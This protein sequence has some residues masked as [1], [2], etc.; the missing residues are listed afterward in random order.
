MGENDEVTRM[1]RMW[2][3]LLA[4]VM[5][6]A[7][8]VPTGVMAEEVSVRYGVVTDE[9][10]AV[11]KKA[12]A[13]ED[14]WFRVDAGHVTPIIDQKT[15]S[16]VLWYKVNTEHPVP[17]GRTY[18]GW[19]R[20]DCIREMTAA[21]IQAYLNG[22]EIPGTD[23]EEDEGGTGMLPSV[24]DALQGGDHTEYTG[25]EVVGGKGVVTVTANFRSD[26]STKT[27][28]IHCEI[29][30]GTEVEIT[31]VPLE[32][33]TNGWYRVTYN[34]KHGYV[35]C[36]LI[37]LLDAGSDPTPDPGFGTEVTGVYGEVNTTK[38]NFRRDAYKDSTNANVI[39]QLNPGQQF[40][41]LTVPDTVSTQTWYRVRYNGE[42]GY[43]Q[44]NFVTIVSGETPAPVLPDQGD[45]EVTITATGMIT[46]DKVNFRHE[47]DAESAIY[48]K[49]HTGTVVELLSIPTKIDSDHWYKVRY[50]G[51]T[52]YIQ[53]PYIRVL[54]VDEDALPSVE[55]FGY[56]KLLEDSVNLRVSAGGDPIVSWKGKGTLLR[57]TGEAVFNSGYNWYPVYYASAHAIYFV[58]EDM[59]QVMVVEGGE[60]NTPAPTESSF[61][62]IVTTKVGVN[63]RTIDAQGNVGGSQ[64]QVPKNTI[65]ACIG[66]AMTPDETNSSYTWYKVR[67]RGIVG[68]LRGDCVRVCTST[69]GDIVDP[70]PEV[71]TP[72]AADALSG[73]IRLIKDDVFL[74]K[75]EGGNPLTQLPLGLI[76]PYYGEITPAGK[77]G[78]YS[79][80]H[81]KTADGL[82]GYI[83]GDCAAICDESGVEV[84]PKPDG[85]DVTG[86]K[87][88]LVKKANFRE[89]ATTDS[90]KLGEI[91]LNT[92]VDVLFVPNNKVN[93]WYKIQ[94][95]GQTGYVLGSLIEVVEADS[96]VTPGPETSAFG[97]L[98]I[99]DEKVA[100]RNA[101][102]GNTVYTRLEKGTVWPLTGL[103]KEVGEVKWYPVNVNGQKG[104]VHG[105]FSFKLSPTQEESYLAGNGVP[106]ENPEVDNALTSYIIAT[107]SVNLRASYST[108]S[109]KMGEIKK[110]T[111]LYYSDTK[112]VGG[113][114]TWYNVVYDHKS[115]WVHGNFVKVMTNKEYQDYIASNPEE[116]PDTSA[117]LGYVKLIMDKV[118]IRDSAAGSAIDQ[119]RI[120]TVLPYYVENVDDAAGNYKWYRIS[121]EDGKFG[122]IRADMVEKC[123]ENG[124]PLPL[125]EPDLGETTS[126]PQTQ[127]MT[128]YTNLYQ[129]MTN[130]DAN[131]ARVR[132]LVQELINQGYYTGEMTSSYTTQVKEAVKLFQTAKGLSATGTA[133]S[134]TQHALF[135]TRPD[136]AGDTSNL[137]FVHY[138]AEKIDWFTGG[139]Q[140]LLPRGSKFKI[141]DVKTG[142]V[143]W[144]YRQ[145]GGKHMDIET[146][147]AA[148]SKRLC[149]IYG[150]DTLQEI[151][152]EN[153]WYP[154]RACLVTIGTRTFA[155]SLDGMQHGD[156]TIANNGMDGQVC[157]HFYNSQGHS[158]GEV[159]TSHAEAVE[160]A[161]Q[162]AP[163]GKK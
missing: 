59:I 135:G 19:I 110:G 6:L 4:I 144:A 131:Q 97:Y 101:P 71:T 149:Q 82:E 81:V 63:L 26:P 40:E 88:R 15:V 163:G 13:N 43:I 157:L 122:Y 70:E 12:G 86:V 117:I 23:E 39:V 137:D 102:G 124:D 83:R 62:Y 127:Q 53:A 113:T 116:E 61:G 115:V 32:G 72:P 119:L 24:D 104:Y 112:T 67:Y 18:I 107:D 105:G 118:Y 79:W 159:S 5:C 80:Y 47:D 68:Y 55:L 142:I 143:F 76:L 96:E 111:V 54:S 114:V 21:E 50:N 109:T 85:T 158:S 139:I 37:E 10:V 42:V 129:G 38:V 75:D 57:I 1:K 156:D 147:T 125:P 64:A 31:G 22:Q 145:A 65:L 25:R 132:N 90:K 17:N 58:R 148:D 140:E 36:D 136:G 73:Y 2:K 120:G 78:K 161:Y 91:P 74:R 60:L 126:A 44:A 48:G 154:R 155:C 92:I 33:D 28:T 46:A 152:D 14:L 77:V 160:Y 49:V 108:D 52:G 134:A 146:L 130:S 8:I 121:L 100:L 27:G 51:N 7:L 153:M 95:N 133:D 34:G 45:G 35:Y 3:Q 66:P 128:K 9:Q 106:E 94:Y 87:G 11:R 138:P 41:I 162:H 103:Y 16:G 99:S 69:G 141:Y 29:A 93:G 56:A 151:V 123:L 150:T 89:E 98:M 30:K 84:T 20:E